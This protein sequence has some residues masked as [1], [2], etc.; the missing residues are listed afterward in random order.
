MRWLAILA[1]LTY[2]AVVRPLR[3]RRCLHA[4]SCSAFAIRTL[5]ADGAWRAVPAIRARIRGCRFPASAS[6]VL[7]RDGQARLLTAASIDGQAIPPMALDVLAAHATETALRARG[8][9]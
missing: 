4:E 8:A 7:G 9:R 6:F 5:R 2:R 1:V 3:P